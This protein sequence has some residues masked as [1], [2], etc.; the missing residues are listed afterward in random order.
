MEKNPFEELPIR[1]KLKMTENIGKM[2]D[3]L[4]Q[5]NQ[6]KLYEEA[7]ELKKESIYLSEEIQQSV[8]MFVEQLLF[9]YQYD[10]GEITEEVRKMADRLIASLGFLPPGERKDVSGID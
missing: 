3:W 9:Q 7:E 4:Y 6:K 2:M 1:T 5:G 8:L 10:P